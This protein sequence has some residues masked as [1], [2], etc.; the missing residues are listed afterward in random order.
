MSEV[1]KIEINGE[2]NRSQLADQSTKVMM[3]FTLPSIDTI[4]LR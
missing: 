3:K 1:R 2:T 4:R